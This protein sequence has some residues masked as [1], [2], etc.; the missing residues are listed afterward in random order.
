MFNSI[1]L[2]TSTLPDILSDCS[3]RIAKTIMHIQRNNKKLLIL[4]IWK[5]PKDN[6]DYAATVSKYSTSKLTTSFNITS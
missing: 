3:R 4:K 5:F 1:F 6:S 2:I